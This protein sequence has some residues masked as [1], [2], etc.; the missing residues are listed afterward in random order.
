MAALSQRM[1]DAGRRFCFL[2]TDLSNPTSNAIY[3]HIGY[4]PVC[5]V[6][7][8]HFEASQPASRH[9]GPRGAAT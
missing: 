8:L 1:L 2:Y 4:E 5:D 3:Q 6:V 7:D 9:P